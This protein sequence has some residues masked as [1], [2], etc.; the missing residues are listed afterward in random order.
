MKILKTYSLIITGL[1]LF[2][3]IAAFYSKDN[4]KTYKLYESAGH[5][6]NK[7]IIKFNHGLHIKDA[8]MK[9]VDCH[10]Y[11]EKSEKSDVSLNPSKQIC[12]SCHDVNDKTKCTLCHYEGVYKKLSSCNR[13]IIF[14][15]NFHISK[16]KKACTDCH[17]GL[18]KVKY[19]GDSEGG[20]PSMET[21]YSCHNQQSANSNCE[22]CHMDLTKLKP[23]NHL[24]SNFLN[25]HKIQVDYATNRSNNNCM[26]CHSDNFCQ[27]CHSASGYKGS[28][29]PKDFYAP[30][31]T[32]ESGVR[33]DKA[34]LQKLSNVHNLNYVYTHGLD[35]GQKAYEC[36]TC[37]DPVEFC[38]ACHSSGGNLQTGMAPSSHL[39]TGFTTFGA[40]TGGGIHAKLAKKDIE[41]CE[42][43]H[44]V[45]G[46]DPLCVKCHYDNDGVRGTNPKTHEYGFL[47]DEKGIWHNTAGAI[48]Y[49]CH[50]DPNARPNG[51]N[52]VGF[53]GY[54][55]GK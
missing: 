55:H 25:E 10:A 9:C 6:D 43:C 33:R 19:A 11:A 38:S 8:G 1:I 28:N 31:Y 27:V 15:H 46:A 20:Y 53:C 40:N 52:G 50:T 12:S 26:M 45:N 36:K 48:C 7:K 14:S 32:Y 5:N 17:T 24:S 47:S 39:Q 16:Q 21:C 44:S 37:H 35:A 29:N 4:V 13:G 18:D 54:C 34:E 49:V 42:A 23:K 41:S 2:F 3:G 22:A 30:F 51:I